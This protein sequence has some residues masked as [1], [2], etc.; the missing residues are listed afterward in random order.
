VQIVTCLADYDDS[1]SAFVA[2]TMAGQAASVAVY[3]RILQPLYPAAADACWSWSVTATPPT[4]WSEPQQKAV[5]DQL[6]RI[7]KSGRLHQSR[8]RQ[9]FHENILNETLAGRGERLKG[10]NVA[11]AVFDR[12]ETFDSNI[13]PS[14]RMEAARLRDRLREYY[15]TDGQDDSIRIELPKGTYTPL[16]EFRDAATS[17]GSP[18]RPDEAHAAQGKTPSFAEAAIGHDQTSLR[19]AWSTRRGNMPVLALILVLGGLGG[20]LLDDLWLPKR[21][22]DDPAL[23]LPTVPAIAVL[24]F[25]NLSGDPKQ[26]YFSDGLTDDILTELSR[27]RDLRVLAR[28]TSF[29]FTDDA[30][31]V[32]KLG[33][34]LKVRY[35][36]KGTVRR[37]D[38]RLRVTAQLIDASTG[39]HV[40]ADR[41]DREMADVLLVQDDIVNQIV[42][43]I[44]GSYGAI[45]SA[46]ARSAARKSPDQIQA[47]DLVL[48]ARNA[49]QF[50]WTKDTF[51]QAEGFLRQAIVLDPSNAQARRELAWFGVMGWV[52]RLDETLV[53][54]N[55]IVAQ[56]AKAVQ[57][58]PA[59]ARARMV[60]ASAYFF[61]KQLDLFARE[62]DQALALA[63]YDAE[64]MATL[65]CMISASGDHQRGVALAERA[66]ALNADVSIGWYHSTV[67]T[68]EYLNGDYA[69]ALK[70]ARENP[71]QEAFYSHLEIIPILGQLGRKQEARESWQALVKLYPGATAASF[72]DWWRLWNIRDAEI[73]RLM[74]G[75][76]RSG[77]LGEAARPSQ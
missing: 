70:V 74:D 50:E 3:Y 22:A 57:L 52:F 28:N 63:P 43:K 54:Q 5:R 68:A 47:Y 60:A 26:D 25:T 64:I 20:W 1:S 46:E 61:T 53:P 35:L 69:H 19:S 65:A 18:D 42:A 49:I 29:Q 12:E 2:N 44:A 32:G 30:E 38:D 13:D 7:I 48:R 9:R 39:S 73:A 27:A 56:A 55:E 33:R 41:Y 4:C 62:G 72:E 77:V 76:Y 17:D 58:D 36:L 66:N 34:E 75:V 67:Y 11:L 15:D 31:D 14:V 40:W 45:E 37:N 8:R 23:G 6:E 24:P 10:Y 59:D 16:I 71:Q 21:A 51:R